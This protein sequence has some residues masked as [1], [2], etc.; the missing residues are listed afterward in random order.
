M[1]I[2]EVV[3]PH[4]LNKI[5]IKPDD[6]RYQMYRDT[7]EKYTSDSG[8]ISDLLH[9]MYKGSTVPNANNLN[10]E[11]IKMLDD[12]MYHH[13]IKRSIIV[14]HGTK[15]SPFKLWFKDRVPLNQPVLEH[16]PAYIS[17]STDFDTASIFAREDEIVIPRDITKYIRGNKK[18]FID[19]ET[20]NDDYFIDNEKYNHDQSNDAIATPNILKIRVPRGTPGLS[21]ESISDHPGE[22]EILLGRGLEIQINPYP[23]YIKENGLVWDC[24]VKYINPTPE[25]FKES[26]I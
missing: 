8:N 12:I 13:P 1:L 10:I 16:F 22:N 18:D 20:Y 15:Y 11:E 19:N 24:K 9:K 3:D 17:T 7:I 26:R 5:D 4:I 23:T 2:K 6:P 14:Y 25:F 21:V